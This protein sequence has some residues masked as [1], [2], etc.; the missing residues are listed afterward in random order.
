MGGQGL[1]QQRIVVALILA[2][3]ISGACTYLLSKR[4][5]A[6]ATA[7]SIPDIMYAAPSRP[8]Q[9]GEVLKPDSVE[10]IAW[11]GTK[12]LRGAF[13]KTADLVGR[14]LL[15]PLERDQPVLE[16]DLSAVGAGAG[17][18]SRIPDGMRAI[19][20]RSDEVVGVA[21][22]LV[23]G[24]RVDVLVTLRIAQS[25]DPV[26]ATV[27]QN[28]EVLAVGQRAQPDPDGKPTAAVTVVTLLLTPDQ[29]ERAV[30]ASAQGSVHFVLRNGADMGHAEP[31][32]MQLS[33]LAGGLAAPAVKQEPA[34]APAAQ[35][36]IESAPR[37]A[38]IET[39]LGGDAPAASGGG[40]R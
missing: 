13:L 34:A 20:L 9:A 26:T 2:L 8:L 30:L 35:P 28:A 1:K 10:L 5:S 11:P 23:P 31:A 27:L 7:K 38:G 12:P 40:Q 15:F 24:S 16:R 4:M 39:V 6:R 17:L 36:R 32:P 37:A 21:G 3:V 14:T 19:A 22:F 29:A 33:M 18:A 25:A